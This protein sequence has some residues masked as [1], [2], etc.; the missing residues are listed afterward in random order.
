MINYHDK[1]IEVFCKDLAYFEGDLGFRVLQIETE[2]NHSK[3]EIDVVLKGKKKS[4]LV[5]VKSNSNGQGKFLTKQFSS[6]R[7]FNP[8]AD[9]Y[10]LMGNCEKSLDLCDLSFQQ[11]HNSNY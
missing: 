4:A 6:Y 7:H 9:V 2:V 1:L 3:G 11:F 8:E 5:E 10:L